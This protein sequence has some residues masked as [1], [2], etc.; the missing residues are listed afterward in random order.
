MARSIRSAAQAHGD[1]FLQCTFASH[2]SRICGFQGSFVC[3]CVCMYV[4]VYVCVCVC[5]CLCVC[6]CLCLCV[7]VCVTL[8]V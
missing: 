6:L 8:R 7:C 3:V 5:V 2:Q 4:C 1:A